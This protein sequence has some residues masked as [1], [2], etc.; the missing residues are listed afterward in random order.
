M[1][2]QSI[3]RQLVFTCAL[4]CAVILSGC[5]GSK[6]LKEPQ[7]IEIKQPLATASDERLSA[8][9]NWVIVRDGPGT[10]AKN[11]DWDEYLMRVQNRSDEPIRVTKIV[12]FDSL[13]TQIEPVGNRSML[14]DRSKDVARRYKDEGLKVKAGEGA[15]TLAV[16]GGVLTVAG[17]A[18]GI[19]ALS[20]STSALAASSAAAGAV[21]LGPVLL[22]SGAVAGMVKTINNQEVGEQIYSRHT[23]LPAVLTAAQEQRLDLFFPLA[24]SP[25]QIEITYVDSRGQH[26]LIIDTQAAL[27]GLHLAQVEK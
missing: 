7:P 19:A 24:P 17:A 10:W 4:A 13:G 3:G 16:A 22:V 5:G 14:V 23:L 26:T 11:A 25:S 20:G 9:L 6:V 2:S 21:V 8:I 18:V 12:V 1:G 15:E 27:E